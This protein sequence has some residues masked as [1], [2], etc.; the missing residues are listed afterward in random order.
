MERSGESHSLWYHLNWL[1]DLVFSECSLLSE[2]EQ[3]KDLLG[4]HI[5]VND[6]DSSEVDSHED[7]QCLCTAPQGS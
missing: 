4:L 3:E 1:L 7:I 6:A 5:A 2:I